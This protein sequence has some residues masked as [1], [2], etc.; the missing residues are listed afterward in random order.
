MTS[1]LILPRFPPRFPTRGEPVLSFR[2]IATSTHRRT[3]QVPPDERWTPHSPEKDA[4]EWVFCRDLP[5]S[6]RTRPAADLLSALR[7]GRP[8][9]IDGAV[10]DGDVQLAAADYA[11]KLV[12][13]HSVFRG[14]LHLTECRFAHTVDLTG[15]EFRE[16]INLFATRIDGQL[17]LPRAVIRR[18]ARPPVVHNFDQI[19]VRGRLNGTRLTTE[20]GLSF[21][22]AQLG[23]VGF[24]GIHAACDLELTLAAVAGDFFCES[25]EGARAEVAGRVSLFG[26]RIGG[27][28][29]FR[30][31]RIGGGLNLADA[32]IREDLRCG[33]Q[34]DQ[35]CEILGPVRMTGAKIGGMAYFGGARLG[36]AIPAGGL[37]HNAVWLQAAEIARGLHFA[38]EG[39]HTTEI[40]GNVFGVSARV[41][42]QLSFD[43]CHVHGD[44][45]LERAVINGRLLFGYD[46]DYYRLTPDAL[47]HDCPGRLQL[48]GKL[49]LSGVQAHDLVLDGRLF[50]ACDGPAETSPTRRD[51]R[52]TF[53][54]RMLTGALEPA[55]DDSR[56]RLD[57]AHLSKLQLDEKIPEGISADGLAF[58]DLQLP[59]G[60]CEYSELARRTRPFKKSTYLAI[61][62]W[63]RNKG[64][65]AEAARVYID[66]S[67]RDL[68]AGQSPRLG[69]WLRWLGLG[70]TIGYGARP[71]RLLWL[72]LLAFTFSMWV[73]S[74]SDSLVSYSERQAL[75]PDPW[76]AEAQR[77]WVTAGVALRCHFPMLLFIG[78]PNFVPSPHRVPWLAGLTYDGYALLVSAVSWVLVP[79]FIAGITGIVRQKA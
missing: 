59:R 2:A 48:D 42:H 16:G 75:Q 56:L 33:L 51:E 60:G 46:R 38:P 6:E 14:Q 44:V 61:E 13:L 35:R 63:L 30:G 43:R 23:E 5:E 3:P 28:A 72:F 77:V 40:H 32:E 62:A 9:H 18:G 68:N 1:V 29:T 39:K 57:R 36:A 47:G 70:L 22:Q 76:P 20:I 19:E 69:R 52:K 65:D 54:R 26:A 25:E 49:L 10:I 21:R 8:I 71:L 17:K 31:A 55:E 64:F 41:S 73:F 4:L 37:C 67:D 74:H 78:E 7:A 79:L 58:D 50:D 66:M 27:H 53:F 34:G 11:H 15:C 24:D 12:I 45:D